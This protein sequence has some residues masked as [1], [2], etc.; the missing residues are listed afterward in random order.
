LASPAING[1]LRQ[2][3]DLLDRACAGK[4]VIVKRIAVCVGCL[5]LGL[6]AFGTTAAHA[7]RGPVTRSYRERSVGV[8]VSTSQNFTST[9]GRVSG[10]PISRGTGSG[11]QAAGAAPPVCAIGST[12]VSGSTTTVAANGDIL[13]SSFSGSVCESVVTPT[14]GTYVV[15]ATFTITGG[16]GR[17]AGATG[18]GTLS[19]TA[20]LHETPFGSQGPVLSHS[21]GTITLA[22]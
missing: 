5:V 9:S 4:W 6:L 2:I 21:L 17:F 20:V 13:D 19:S 8:I 1:A 22:R 11:T 12:S 18:G 14:S 3:R 10:T 15:T 7:A 16:T